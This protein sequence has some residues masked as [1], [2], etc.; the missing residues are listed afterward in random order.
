LCCLTESELVLVA[1][2]VATALGLSQ[3]AVTLTSWVL[4]IIPI[5]RRS[6]ESAGKWRLTYDVEVESS[7]AA[8][9]IAETISSSDTIS[10][11][12]SQIEEDI[13]SSTISI[14]DSTATVTVIGEG[15]KG[16]DVL[17]PVL[18]STIM[19]VL[20]AFAIYW[21]CKRSDAKVVKKAVLY[22]DVEI[23]RTTSSG[24]FTTA[25]GELTSV[26]EGE[27][28]TEPEGTERKLDHEQGAEVERKVII[29]KNTN[30]AS[31]T[32]GEEQIITTHGQTSNTIE[33]LSKGNKDVGKAELQIMGGRL[34]P[35]LETVE[36]NSR[37]LGKRRISI[38][39]Y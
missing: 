32:L 21:Y 16:I 18:I 33:E 38:Q 12:E 23:V 13:S 19:L 4:V 37:E 10:A 5:E 24:K 28:E 17:I 9:V 3:G 27:G 11:L 20:I 8:N 22:A 7:D 26:H 36:I 2:A 35:E 31:T 14:T 15:K 30:L 29:A 25:S 34:D 6:G 1:A 39:R